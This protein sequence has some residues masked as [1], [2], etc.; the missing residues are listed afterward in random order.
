MASHFVCPD[1]DGDLDTAA[2]FSTT[3]TRYGLRCPTP[4]CGQDF[5]AFERVRGG[6]TTRPKRLL[7]GGRR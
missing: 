7:T 2:D 1:C 5:V 4:A 3:P 6:S